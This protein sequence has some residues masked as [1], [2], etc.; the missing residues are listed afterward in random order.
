[1][2]P[3]TEL[4]I[5]TLFGADR[6]VH[7]IEFRSCPDARDS[8]P[9][10]AV[11]TRDA[12]V[13]DL[14]LKRTDRDGMA[15]YVGICTRRLGISKGDRANAMECPALWADIDLAK[16]GLDS[17]Q[18][19]AALAS[20]PMPPS[21]IVHS[22]GGLH[23][24]WLLKEA[25]CVELGQDDAQETEDRLV[26]VLRQLAGVFA[27]DLAVCELARILRLPGTHNSKPSVVAANG[28]VPAV[29][30]LIE[31]DSQRTYE[32]DDMEEW[33][34][35]QRPLVERPAAAA[36]PSNSANPNPYSAYAA[37]AG[38]HPPIDVAAML[39]AMR[40]QGDGD[41]SVHQ[42]QLKVSAALVA[43]GE[44]EETVLAV[45]LAATEAAVGPQG[46]FWNW[47][48][49]ERAIRQ[50]IAGARAK[51]GDAKP[52]A[53]S[54]PPPRD[55]SPRPGAGD[56]STPQADSGNVVSLSDARAAK[57][58][59]V[60]EPKPK[61]PSV[62]EQVGQIVIARWQNEVGPLL[63]TPDQ[64][65]TYQAG[66]WQPIELELMQ[67]LRSWIQGAILH[68]K[69]EPRLQMKA[70]VLAYISD[71][72]ELHRASVPWDASGL[73][74]CR[75]GA[76]DPM[77]GVLH[78]HS[79]DHY[80][81][82]GL[83]LEYRPDATAPIFRQFLAESFADLD[84]AERDAT[85]DTLMEFFGAAL[86]RGKTREMTKA[87]FIVGKTR[88]GKTQLLMVL[89]ALVGGRASGIRAAML[90]ER[91]GLQPLVGASGWLADDAISQNEQ[92]DPE[93]FKVVVTGEPTSIARKNTTNWEGSLDIPVALTANHLP[94]VKD[95]SDAVYNRSLVARM[96]NERPVETSAPR[97]IGEIIVKQELAGVLALAVEGYRRLRSRGH[98]APPP[99]ML[100]ANADF[101]NDNQPVLLFLKECFT[102]EAHFMVDRRDVMAAFQAWWR[103]EFADDRLL[104]ARAFWPAMRSVFPAIE[105]HKSHG[106]R[107]VTGIKLTEDGIERVRQYQENHYGTDNSS[108]RRGDDLNR[109]IP[110]K[111]EPRF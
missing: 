13:I 4:F 50:M 58:K 26:A 22:G 43:R 1:M 74:I 103:D 86:V 51:Y 6:T 107:Y 93:M 23:A 45:L 56:G 18:V 25:A 66:W 30:R 37:A 84:P 16:L 49:E 32:L 39:A 55:D 108:G 7:A 99:G 46:Q 81:T 12:R 92:I 89:R 59:P 64:L 77:T 11:F 82:R 5:A 52:K 75:N 63:V 78:A 96:E 94:R 76:L 8:K 35:Y 83:D 110:T 105:D 29:V 3:S 85:I 73:I 101:R 44:D 88:S 80:A 34:S 71:H 20:C 9:A 72:T 106:S 70:N 100:K 54:P 65:W 24:Y 98:Y 79:P 47:K 61:T 41:A 48:R 42:T 57:A 67:R 14:H 31:C 97:P 53:K 36:A 27:G 91:F 10:R 40:Y 69:E 28:G 19:L 17:S 102:A 95:D 68:L 15:V 33:L 90:G 62:I 109:I 2:E 104:S 60:K 87:L 21:I 111:Q 38:Y